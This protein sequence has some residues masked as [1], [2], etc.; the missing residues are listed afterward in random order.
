MIGMTLREEWLIPHEILIFQRGTFQIPLFIGFI[1][2]WEVS[3]GPGKMD[4]QLREVRLSFAVGK[5]HPF[6]SR[7]PSV[8]EVGGLLRLSYTNWERP[9]SNFIFNNFPHFTVYFKF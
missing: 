9:A 4:Q 2:F 3:Q 6:F 7:S 1:V 8:I 5:N